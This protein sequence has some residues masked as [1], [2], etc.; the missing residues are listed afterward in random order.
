M[1]N[2]KVH[3]EKLIEVISDKEF[4]GLINEDSVTDKLIEYGY[5]YIDEENYRKAFK[6][7]IFLT[8]LYSQNTKIQDIDIDIL[9][10]L[11]LSLSGLSRF[12][13]SKT[14]FEKILE[15]HSDD[16]IT[17][18]SIAGLYWDQNDI[19]KA[20]YYYNKSLK[21]DPSIEETYFNLINLYYE[22]G[23]YFMAYIS[24]LNLIEVYPENIE[25]RETIDDLMVDMGILIS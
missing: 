20:I 11:G 23:D 8:R 7:F 16:V 24:C 1:K 14:I 18:I 19:D 10:G 17:Y 22:Q 2:R 21:L 15:S 3:I 13:V 5:D 4:W 6:I 25:A 12:T 9:N